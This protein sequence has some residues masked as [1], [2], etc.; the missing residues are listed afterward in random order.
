MVLGSV[1]SLSRA[2]S[3]VIEPQH[4]FQQTDRLTQGLSGTT[5]ERIPHL[6]EAKHPSNVVKELMLN[7][8]KSLHMYGGE[9]AFIVSKKLTQLLIQEKSRIWK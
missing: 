5:R 1:W 8:W 6:T 2:S 3:E 7:G 9:T 4:C